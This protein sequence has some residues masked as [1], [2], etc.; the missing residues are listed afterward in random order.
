MDDAAL[1]WNIALVGDPNDTVALSGLARFIWRLERPAKRRLGWRSRPSILREGK[2]TARSRSACCRYRVYRAQGQSDTKAQQVIEHAMLTFPN[3]EV[4]VAEQE[5]I[6]NPPPTPVTVA[7]AKKPESKPGPKAPPKLEPVPT[8]PGTPPA[9]LPAATSSASSM[10]P[11]TSPASTSPASSTSPAATP[12]A[13]SPATSPATLPPATTTPAP[14]RRP[15]RPSPPRRRP[16][17]QNPHR[18][19]PPRRSPRR[20][21]PR[22]SPHRRHR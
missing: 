14:A 22:Q 19:Q 6:K 4:L 7:A 3:N 10:P 16:A 20:C 2:I 12:L 17:R 15:A 11:A 21:H 8:A 9:S 5:S 13:T 18:R 1:D